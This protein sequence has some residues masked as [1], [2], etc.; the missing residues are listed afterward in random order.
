MPFAL[1]LPIRGRY[2]IKA[3]DVFQD[4]N[5]FPR[6]LYSCFVCCSCCCTQLILNERSAQLKLS[7]RNNKTRGSRKISNGVPGVPN[8]C[9]LTPCKKYEY[10]T[11]V[12]RTSSLSLSFNQ[13]EKVH[14]AKLPHNSAYGRLFL[15][16]YTVPPLAAR[17]C[18]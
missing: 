3:Q 15:E 18:D 16:W 7:R 4:T 8:R 9:F 11:L 17:W 14:R 10:T 2:S 6:L 13:Y 12:M 1:H 5:P